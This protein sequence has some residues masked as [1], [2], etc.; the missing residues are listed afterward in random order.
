MREHGYERLDQ[1]RGAMNFDRCPEA[2]AFERG[3][4]QRL[5]QSWRT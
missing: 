2:A 5:L 4:Y 3:H 1:F